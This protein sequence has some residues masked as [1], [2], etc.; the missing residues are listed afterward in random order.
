MNTDFLLASNP[1]SLLGVLIVIFVF[2]ACPVLALT[3]FIASGVLYAQ[4]ER[5]PA[6]VYALLGLLCTLAPLSLGI[7]MWFFV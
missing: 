7:L 3:F 5:K 6:I 4:K 2:F 1:P